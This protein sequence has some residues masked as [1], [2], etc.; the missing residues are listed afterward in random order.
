MLVDERCN[1]DKRAFLAAGEHVAR[2]VPRLLSDSSE[3]H[4]LDNVARTV[5]WLRQR[6]R[7]LSVARAIYLGLPGDPK[8]WLRG[9]EFV[10]VDRKSLAATLGAA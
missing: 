5:G 9:R 10:D 4:Q 3:T 1:R 2:W 8:L 6:P 7:T